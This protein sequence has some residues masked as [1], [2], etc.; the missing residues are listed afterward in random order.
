MP[1]AARR[2][3]VAAISRPRMHGHVCITSGLLHIAP[4]TLQAGMIRRLSLD[5]HDVRALWASRGRA[6]RSD[7]LLDE[8][9][10]SLI[11]VF[12]EEHCRA[13]PVFKKALRNRVSR[14]VYIEHGACFLE[15]IQTGLYTQLVEAHPQLKIGQ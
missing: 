8:H 14:D 13:S 3:I 4:R 5:D 12:W 6:L 2:A 15:H 10:T 7:R 1:L 9:T 11:E